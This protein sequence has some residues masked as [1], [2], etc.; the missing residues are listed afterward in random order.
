MET[1]TY[2]KEQIQRLYNIINSLN[3]TGVQSAMMLVEIHNI[4]NSPIVDEN[5]ENQDKNNKIKEWYHGN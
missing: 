3:F 1:V 5:N 4:I 2:S